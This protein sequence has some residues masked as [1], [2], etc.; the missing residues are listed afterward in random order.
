MLLNLKL[1]HT[2][3][4]SVPIGFDGDIDGRRWLG[5]HSGTFL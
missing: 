4:D 1:H 2:E 3:V 5:G